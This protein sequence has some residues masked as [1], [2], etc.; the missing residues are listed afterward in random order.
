MVDGAATPR[1]SAYYW[2]SISDFLAADPMALLG[3]L[4]SSHE[5]AVDPTQQQAWEQELHILRDVVKGLAGAIYLEFEVPRLGSRIDAVIVSGAAVLPIEFKCGESE[6]RKNDYNQ[7]WDYGLDLKNFHQASHDVAIF[8]LLVATEAIGSDASWHTSHTD[9]VRPPRRVNSQDVQVAISEAIALAIGPA[10]NTDGWGRAPYRPTPTII[11]AARALYSHHSVEQISRNDAGAQN[12]H[13]TTTAID[14]IVNSSATRNER[15]IVFV[16]GV[17]GAGKTLVGLDVVTRRRDL[18]QTH[19]V[20]LSGNGPLV[21]VLREALT[22]DEISRLGT[23][24][25]EVLQK[26][27][28]FIQN[29][30][31]FRDDGLRDIAAPPSDHVVIFDEAQR[32]WNLPKTASF[33]KQRKGV[34]NF[35]HSEPIRRNPR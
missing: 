1:V 18:E 34:A 33:M 30:H 5:H 8:P 4:S 14:S 25:G 9:G 26:V 29:I 20:Y 13:S 3:T 2:S 23:R 35:T 15:A 12:L 16:T 22:R 24:R 17:P 11:E 32:A 28:A 27:K 21:A 10:I 7:A 31:H 6:F 19:A